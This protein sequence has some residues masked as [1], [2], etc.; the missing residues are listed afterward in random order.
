MGQKTT[1]Y[2]Y[3]VYK[4]PDF[5]YPLN[6]SISK[7]IHVQELLCRKSR[8]VGEG[9]DERYVVT[10]QVIKDNKNM[11]VVILLFIL[12]YSGLVGHIPYV[13]EMIKNEN[14]YPS[15]STVKYYTDYKT[16]Y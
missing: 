5:H 6:K 7:I 3:N 15:S 8:A 12:K 16:I 4:T 2:E 13:E 14:Y 11:G 10:L 1:L 9:E